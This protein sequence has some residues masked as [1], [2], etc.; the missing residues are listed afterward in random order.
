MASTRNGRKWISAEELV[1]QLDRD[2]E[3]KARI[4]EIER[5]R[6]VLVAKNFRDAQP[7]VA[8]LTG[9]GFDVKTPADLFNK[10]MNYRA[11]IPMLIEWLPR[12]SNSDVKADVVRALSVKWAKPAAI[13][14]LLKEFERAQGDILRW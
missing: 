10:R 3:Y 8:Q 5:R 11:A 9:R 7:L 4:A 14:V 13:P 6:L 12:I 2:P 1:T